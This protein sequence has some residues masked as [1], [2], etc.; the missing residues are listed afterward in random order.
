MMTSAQVVKT[1]VNVTNNSPFRDYSHPDD[2]TTQTTETPGFKPSTVLI[3]EILINYVTLP[4]PQKKK[5]N[6]KQFSFFFRTIFLLK[7][8]IQ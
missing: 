1:L 5:R 8:N 2:Q 6:G 3:C 4:S 7:K